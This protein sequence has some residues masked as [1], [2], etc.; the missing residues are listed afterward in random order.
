[1]HSLSLRSEPPSFTA[2][3]SLNSTV[4]TF[5]N[6]SLWLWLRIA[7]QGGNFE[8]MM[9]LLLPSLCSSY[10]SISNCLT[11]CFQET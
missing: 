8:I 10:Y 6:L 9:M 5:S 4:V 3:S 7:G 2:I 11:K 1:M